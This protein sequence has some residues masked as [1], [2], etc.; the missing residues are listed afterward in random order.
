M[1]ISF[2]GLHSS[3]CVG[4]CPKPN[5]A[6]LCP[7]TDLYLEALMSPSASEY[8]SSATTPAPWPNASPQTH[9]RDFRDGSVASTPAPSPFWPQ[10]NFHQGKMLLLG[11]VH[12]TD[13]S[14]SSGHGTGQHLE[15]TSASRGIHMRLY[16]SVLCLLLSWLSNQLAVWVPR[17]WNEYYLDPPPQ[18]SCVHTCQLSSFGVNN[19]KTSMKGSR[20]ARYITSASLEEHLRQQCWRCFC[21]H[22]WAAWQL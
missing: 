17:C 10:S 3:V 9:A 5:S 1:L 7:G 22:C 2:K 16:A 21:R 20:A 19:Q 18:V 12:S 4:D 15:I 11:F 8:T 13:K 6:L 14:S